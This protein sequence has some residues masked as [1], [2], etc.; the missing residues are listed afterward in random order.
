MNSL[1]G[2]SGR[3]MAYSDEDHL[4]TAGDTSYQYDLD[5]FLSTKTKGTDVITYEYSSLGELLR[6][7]LPNG[8][9]IE[10]IHDPFGRRIAK[11]VDGVIVGK[12]LW[13]G[14][15]RL[16]AV[17]DGSDNLLM[18]FEY[19]DGRMPVAMTKEGAT[20][21]FTYDKVGSLRVVADTSGTWSKGLTT[22]RLG[23]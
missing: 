2:I 12:Y 23:T 21:Y 3:T 6:V 15:T 1:R 7:T 10:Y 17:H 16:L 8:K 20:Y 4:L 22:T 14:M 5:G 18:R 19:A 11:K 13:Q 9:V